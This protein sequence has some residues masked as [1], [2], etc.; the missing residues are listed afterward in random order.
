M[1]EEHCAGLV[2]DEARHNCAQDVMVTGEPGFAETYRISERFEL[3]A[4]PEPPDLLLP[5][6]NQTGV[7]QPISFSWAAAADL[8]DDTVT[9][10][11]CIWAVG[12]MPDDNACEPVSD[13]AG[14][15]GAAGGG[16]AIWLLVAL[17]L[18]VLLFVLLTLMGM[19]KRPALA[20]A[21]AAALL[22]AI[23]LRALF[24]A[25]GAAT[26]SVGLTAD[27]LEPGKAYYW[28]VIA[29]DANGGRS[30]SSFRRFETR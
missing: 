23:L 17:L 4:M 27:G 11:H 25:P 6:D 15:A 7:T 19:A 2:T 1:A 3:N 10:R 29:E 14:T 12:E 21:L 16:W 24:G 18:A 26:G 5:A 28:K 30:E 20:T 22:A 8:D 13:P 9:Y